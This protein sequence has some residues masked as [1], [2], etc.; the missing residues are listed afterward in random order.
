M[1]GWFN[2]GTHGKPLGLNWGG[3]NMQK[4]W[5]V[6]PFHEASGI[7]EGLVRDLPKTSNNL[8]ILVMTATGQGDK[9]GQ[10]NIQYI[11]IYI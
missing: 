6:P 1:A 8:I 10:A 7:F 11:N 2:W 9:M 4:V 3:K 5:V